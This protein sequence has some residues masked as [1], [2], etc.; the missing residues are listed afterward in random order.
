MVLLL[1]Q[2]GVAPYEAQVLKADTLI[3]QHAGEIYVYSE[4]GRG[5]TFR[6]YLPQVEGAPRAVENGASQGVRWGMET[7]V[8]V[9]DNA[10]VRELACTVLREHGY[11]VIEAGDGAECLERLQAYPGPAHLLLA[12]VVMPGMNG[13]E[14]HQRL[15]DQRPALKVLFMSGYTDNVI[16]HQGI[17]DAGIDFLQKPF[18]VESLTRRVREALEESN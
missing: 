10:M 17:L 13:R 11:H 5:T 16:V 9:E 12:D 8:V 2:L 14:L 1:D 15:L 6:I 7:I 4:A 3:K 18:T